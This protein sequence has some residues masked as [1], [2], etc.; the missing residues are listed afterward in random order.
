MSS[1]GGVFLRFQ[2]LRQPREMGSA[3]VNDVRTIFGFISNM[4]V[5]SVAF[6]LPNGQAMKEEFFGKPSRASLL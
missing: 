1:G 6:G 2:Q 4:S 5:K 3:E